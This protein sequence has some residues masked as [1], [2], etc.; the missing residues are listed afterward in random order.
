MC[1]CLC[2][3]VYMSIKSIILAFVRACVHIYIH[4]LYTYM[5]KITLFG[6]LFY[7]HNHIGLKFGVYLLFLIQYSNHFLLCIFLKWRSLCFIKMFGFV[8]TC[9]WED[10]AITLALLRNMALF[11]G[12]HGCWKEKINA[13]F[14]SPFS[15]R[16]HMQEKKINFVFFLPNEKLINSMC[17]AIH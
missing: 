17:W 7:C 3:H 8:L 12:L 10:R 1:I 13:L 16:K 11:R 6:K 2:R 5:H 4:T 14:G 9:I 15:S